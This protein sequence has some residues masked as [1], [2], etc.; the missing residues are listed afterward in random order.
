M[1]KQNVVY[2]Y[3][4]IL[5]SNNAE[6]TLGTCTNLNQFQMHYVKWRKL[7]SECYIWHNCIYM[8]FWKRQTYRDKKPISGYLWTGNIGRDLTTKSIK[9][10]LGWEK[11]SISWLRWCY[12]TVW[13]CQNLL[14]LKRADFTIYKLLFNKPDLQ[15]KE[16]N[17]FCDQESSFFIRLKKTQ[18]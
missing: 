17:V 10:L 2:L 14:H 15:K 6:W 13:V 1:Y 5:L 11:C 7:G 8:T 9:E 18:F 16:N 12:W 4:G 3:S